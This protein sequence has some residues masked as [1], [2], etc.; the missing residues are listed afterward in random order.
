MALAQGAKKV[1]GQALTANELRSCIIGGCCG[2][3][4]P[5]LDIEAVEERLEALPWWQLSADKKVLRRRFTARNFKAAMKFFNEVTTIAEEEGHHPD[6]H[7]TNYRDVTVE[8]T[9]HAIGAL[10]LPDFI[11]ASKLD[12]LDVDYS[13]KWLREHGRPSDGE[14]PNARQVKAREEP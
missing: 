14:D 8:L 12:A 1:V 2:K 6:L 11:L 10:S 9:T 5:K 7:L 4:T 13:P 3:D